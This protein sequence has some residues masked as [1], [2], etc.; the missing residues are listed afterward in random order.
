MRTASRL[1]LN[2][3]PTTFWTPSQQIFTESVPGCLLQCYAFCRQLERNPDG[4]MRRALS[5]ITMSALTT[6]FTSAS[7]SYDYDTNPTE[8]KSQPEFYGYVPNKASSRSVIFFPMTLN[9]ALLLL[10]R[11]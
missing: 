10:V 5:S 4:A 3:K 11:C 2:N 7:I 9:S 1:G 6:G 8:R